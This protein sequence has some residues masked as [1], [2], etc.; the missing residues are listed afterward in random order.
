[1]APSNAVRYQ[2]RIDKDDTIVW[3]NDSWL[4]F[5]KENNAAELTD[6]LVVGRCLWTFIA[7]K[8]TCDIYKS[9]YS[10]VRDRHE[11]AIVPF[12]CDSPNVRRD[13][14][15]TIS[16]DDTDETLLCESV[17]VQVLPHRY[18][19]VLDLERSRTKEILTMCSCCKRVL[20]EPEGWVD[21]EAFCERLRDRGRTIRPATRHSLCLN[22][23]KLLKYFPN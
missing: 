21:V 4:A 15:L 14:R 23:S 5:A 20:V 17:I 12:R 10:R 3:V 13:M 2:Y 6:S 22:C 18:L 1:M 9:L 8:E 7:D 19:S 11:T 16:K